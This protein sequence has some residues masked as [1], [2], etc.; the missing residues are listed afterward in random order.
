MSGEGR[1]VK[2]GRERRPSGREK[3]RAD[4][5]RWWRELTGKGEHLPEQRAD[6]KGGENKG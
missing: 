2:R 1:S 5:Q 4:C 3:E 6:G